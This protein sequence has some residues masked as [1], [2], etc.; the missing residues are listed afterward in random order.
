[1]FTAI[2]LAVSLTWLV[3]DINRAVPLPEG[4]FP[5]SFV[6]TAASIIWCWT[7]VNAAY[8]HQYIGTLD[9][10]IAA[11]KFQHRGRY[12]EVTDVSDER[13]P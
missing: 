3:I 9:K 11:R 5:L 13:K 6:A 4:S 12:Y 2:L 1:M 8:R 7:A 10:A